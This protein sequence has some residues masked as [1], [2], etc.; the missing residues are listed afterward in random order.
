MSFFLYNLYILVR[1]QH[2]CLPDVILIYTVG[3]KRNDF[4]EPV[5]N[6]HSF[7]DANI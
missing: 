1:T 6:K 2:V 3:Q 5:R 7:E 4:I